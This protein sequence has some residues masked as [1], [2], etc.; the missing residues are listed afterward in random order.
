VDAVSCKPNFDL[1]AR[2][3][4]WLE[5]V[6]FARALEHCRFHFLPAL[7]EPRRALILGD[8]DG[9]FLSR[10]L[11]ANPHLYADV[12]DI[13]PAMLHLLNER[14]TPKARTRV[15]LHHA[16]AREF[17]SPA[18]DYDLIVT[19]FF[20]DCLF[21]P[22]LTALVDRIVLRLKPG[23]LWVV[24]EFSRV[25][26]RVGFRLG[27]AVV[28]VLYQAFGLLTGLAVRSL[29]DHCAAFKVHDFQLV[30]EK[31]WLHGLLVSQLWQR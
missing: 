19:H 9:R 27:Q 31:Q 30:S 16:D 26:G 5:Y 15:T 23:A 29:P 18:M 8:G 10:L 6:T 24:S 12:V 22:E 17:I 3:Y 28:S 21:Q 13:S 7:A 14:L 20:F 4:R 1:L 11:Q 2:P 25:H